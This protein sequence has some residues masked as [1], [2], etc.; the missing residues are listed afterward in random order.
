MEIEYLKDKTLKIEVQCFELCE[1]VR[2][3]SDDTKTKVKTLFNFAASIVH[4]G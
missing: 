2:L 4:L 3:S 1:K